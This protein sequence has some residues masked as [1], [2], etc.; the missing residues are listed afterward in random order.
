[1]SY[2]LGSGVDSYEEDRNLYCET[3]DDT[4]D[5]VPC[6]IEGNTGYGSC[7]QCGTELSFDVE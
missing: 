6:T 1:M 3:C 2:W 4:I 7:P 5:D